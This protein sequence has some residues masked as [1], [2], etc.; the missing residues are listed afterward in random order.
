MNRLTVAIMAIALALP[1]IGS[2]HS[3]PRLNPNA[4]PHDWDIGNV[5]D[6]ECYQNMFGM[7]ECAPVGGFPYNG[8]MP[9][10]MP[11]PNFQRY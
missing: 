7:L 1:T 3:L 8:G 11:M 6:V 5:P 4:I 10:P 2:A 9:P